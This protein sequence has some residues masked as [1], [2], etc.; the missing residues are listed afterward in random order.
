MP[1][2]MIT[3]KF[4]P[5]ESA[6]EED[7]QQANPFDELPGLPEEYVPSEPG[8]DFGDGLLGDL[9]EEVECATE[10]PPGY[11]V[12]AV[13]ALAKPGDDE[14]DPVE[15]YGD[16]TYEWID[17]EGL[18]VALKEATTR[19]EMVTLRFF[20]GLKSKT[21]P[22][23]TAG[24]QQLVLK[25]TQRFPLR[26]L[27]CDPGTECTSE[28]LTKWLPGQGVK[29][30]T[31]IPT[32]K[33]GNGLAERVVGWF[34]SRARTLLAA[35]DL[36]AS[37]WPVAMRWA[38]EAHNRT[39]LLQESLPAFGQVV[40]HKLKKPAG[41]H[42]ELITR[43]VKTKYGAPYLTVTDGHVLFTQEG[44]LV[45]SR[46]FRTG[47]I[48]AE[49]LKEAQPPPLQE[50]EAP[51][52]EEELIPD[53]ELPLVS[54]E[55]RL[56][57][58]T[59]VRFVEGG[60]DDD[61]PESLAKIGLLDDNFSNEHFRRLVT[62][63]EGRELPT[64]D[65]R[66]ELQ[67][68]FILGA[69]GHGG[70]RG[71]TTLC[72]SYP[73]LTLYLNKFL[74]AHTREPEY[75]AEWATILLVHA[76]DV[77]IHRD[78]RNEWKTRNFA[79]CVPGVT[80]LWKGPPHK[81]KSEESALVPDWN[82]AD[83][84][85]L[86]DEVKSFDPRC[87]HAVRRSPD[88]VIEED[89]GPPPWDRGPLGATRNSPNA[90]TLPSDLH[91][92]LWQRDIVYLQAE[93]RRWEAERV[94]FGVHPSGTRRTQI[95]ASVG[96]N[97][98]L[99]RRNR[100]VSLQNDR[101]KPNNPVGASSSS[102]GH[103]FPNQVSLQHDWRQPAFSVGASGSLTTSAS[104]DQGSVPGSELPPTSTTG[105]P[106]YA[107]AY[108][109]PDPYEP[110][111]H[112]WEDEWIPTVAAVSAPEQTSVRQHLDKWKGPAQDELD[113]L[114]NMGAIRRHYGAAARH[115]AWS[116]DI[117]NA[118]LLASVHK[119]SSG[120]F[121]RLEYLNEHLGVAN[122]VRGDPSVHAVTAAS[123]TFRTMDPA[124][125]QGMML[126]L[127]LL[128]LQLQPAASQEEEEAEQ[129]DIDLYVV[130][131]MMACSVLFVWELGKHC[132]KQCLY[133]QRPHATS[134]VHLHVST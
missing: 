23:V 85:V 92:F 15:T 80:E 111:S 126:V 69:Y 132:L 19:I 77:P 107:T 68:R 124:E 53:G 62:A 6:P 49:A 2:S 30:Q 130:A 125:G 26:V 28:A 21:G 114:I 13:E 103:E 105:V 127:A 24:I 128:M 9:A 82:S 60:L 112:Y 106:S 56:R 75:P 20:V 52:E 71:V 67:G 83:V 45:A 98:T 59:T 73:K 27:H 34:K 90:D 108:A 65:R 29:L 84:A 42:K 32:D 109:H 58:K 22:D 38:A 18:D 25:I 129:V 115:S 64:A 44:N 33:Q 87:H 110:A 78:Y 122:P 81:G 17:D 101:R 7:A 94:M 4:S 70:Q 118:F 37:Y 96:T 63:L 43:W 5:P 123:R 134:H 61:H 10:P 11:A 121:V 46:G 95:R 88:W 97:L 51:S 86:T 48:D 8:I 100:E 102:S 72:K 99:C 113:S 131:V 1:K 133:E 14:G 119:R 117:K 16:E 39:V 12:E 66:G 31:T 57:E 50:N 36:P 41:G 93:L 120:K 116:T 89:D 40:L 47:V 55:R 74:K 54:P 79:L 76:S 91:L 3:T 35:N 104:F